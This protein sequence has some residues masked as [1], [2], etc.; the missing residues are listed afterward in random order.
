M[1]RKINFTKYLIVFLTA[2]FLL[3]PPAHP[4]A[5]NLLANG[6]FENGNT[7]NWVVYNP[8]GDQKY[9]LNVTTET[10]R[11]HSGIYAAR[12]G[13]YGGNII[14]VFHNTGSV[15]GI[16]TGSMILG[17]V[18]IKTENLAFKEPGTGLMFVLV[19]L[20]AGGNAVTYNRGD[21]IL[22]GTNP[23]HPVDIVTQLAPN[24]VN[25]QL[26]IIMTNAMTS[27]T[28][29]IDDASI[30]TFDMASTRN[31]I[32]DCK[33]IKDAKGTPRLTIDGVTKA[34][35]FFMGNN[36]AGISPVI[37]D[38]MTKAATADVNFIQIIMNLPWNGISN[39][40][41][42]QV[43]QA[44]PKAMLFPRLFLYPPQSW[45]DAHP[46]QIMKNDS[47]ETPNFPSLASDLFFNE[48]K[49]KLDLL[50]RYIHNSPYKNRFMGYHLGYLYGGEWY[51]TDPHLDYSEINRQKFAQW[52]AAKYGTIGPLNTAWNKTYGSFN[53][54]QIPPAAEIEIGDDGLFRNPSIHRA[55]ID[56][57][58]YFNNLSAVRLTELADYIK[59]LT[60]NKSL[61]GFFYGYQLELIPTFS[62]IG[63]GASGHMGLRQLL[64][65]PN[66]DFICSPFSYYDRQPGRPNGMTSIVDSVTAAGKIFLEEDDS[67]TWLWTGADASLYL[68]TEWDTLQCLRRNLGNVVGHNQAIWWMDLVDNGNFNA[69]SI[70][71][72]NKISIDTY[73]D[74]IANQQPTTPQVALIYDQECYLYLKAKSFPLNYPK[75]FLQRSVFQS[76]GAQVGYYYIQDLPKIPSSVKLY[77]F[78]DAFQIDAEKKALIDAIKKN[79]N[80]LLW[81]YAPGYVTENNFSTTSMQQITGFNLGK[82]DSPILTAITITS[83]SHS[84]CQ[85]IIGHTFGAFDSI[86][87]TFYGAGSDGSVILGNY[88]NG[89]SQPALLLKEFP[90]WRSI[91]CGAPILSVPVLR[92]ICRYAGA[93]LLVDPDNMFT[94][95]AVTYNGRYLYVYAR[96]HAGMR[97][98]HVP[99]DPVT[100]VDMLTGIQLISKATSWNVNFDL[101]EQK[102]FKLIPTGITAAKDWTTYSQNKDM[103]LL[104]PH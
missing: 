11:V 32:P 36:Q 18:Y 41:L 101:N 15:S 74:S 54:I 83:S 19:G 17:R 45:I 20:D 87:P 70:W 33:L 28:I 8:S 57:Y 12:L 92:S 58:D 37:F 50:I 3:G 80:T 73:K 21:I 97:T 5:A 91:F 31:D 38:E 7:T 40:V 88:S 39:N 90:A 95:D 102:I 9:A 35:L 104:K 27:G 43:I 44:N 61:V 55:I 16:P 14:F 78:V 53:E 103:A 66:V 67:R 52:T 47:G 34:P 56:Y 81:M 71:D 2:L 6:G 10:A 49:S 13:S 84:I 42:E 89:S 51:Y 93:P 4:Q 23:Y 76:L 75:S 29:C 60:H 68:P 65:S 46:D 79:N 85:G 62:I 25:A 94:E 22:T 48:C 96:T 99:G 64:A 86:A 82:Q 1:P 72:S 63:L 100:V 26:Q 30:D 59:S 77:V 98:L 69:Q 24:V